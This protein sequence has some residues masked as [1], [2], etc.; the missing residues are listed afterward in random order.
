MKKSKFLL[1]VVLMLTLCMLSTVL[2]TACGGDDEGDTSSSVESSTPDSSS[3]DDQN[4]DK[5]AEGRDEFIDSL[6]GVSDTY[7]GAVSE[8]SYDSANEA[9]TAYVNNEVAGNSNVEDVEAVSK[10]ELSANAIKELKLPEELQEGI[11]SVEKFEVSYS[12]SEEE[13]L[14]LAASS[15]SS[16]KIYVYVIR[17]G[18]EYKYYTPCPVNGETIT[19]SY[20]DSVFNTEKYDNCT[21]TKTSVVEVK[22]GTQKLSATIA[23]TIKRDGN[24]ILFEQTVTGDPDL[25][26]QLGATQ[27]YLAAYMEIDENG[28]STTHVKMSESGP[29]QEG[30][31][32]GVNAESVVPFQDQYLDYTYFSKTDFGFALKGDNALRF[33]EETIAAQGQSQYLDDAKLDLYAEY[34]VADGTLSGM[35]MEYSATIKVSA[36]VSSTT[37]GE[38][39]MTCTDYGTTVVEK[40]F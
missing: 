14:S 30:Y 29:W 34:Y 33:Y 1:L 27:P 7:E 21:F 3:K 13:A 10:G 9:A 4:E 24:K 36:F 22:A 35:R 25:T 6:G 2:F 40:P 38:N 37:V 31:L 12:L 19:K 32:Q 15:K 18:K 39:T 8:E 16:Y 26:V 28:R 5:G 23:Q 20:Y 11:T 17:Y